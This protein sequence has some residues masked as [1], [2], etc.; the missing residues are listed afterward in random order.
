MLSQ[1]YALVHQRLLRHEI[2]RTHHKLYKTGRSQTEASTQQYTLTPIESL[3]G[4]QN[5]DH[6]PVLV[7][8]ILIQVE[9]GQYYLEDPTGLVLVSFANAVAVDDFFVT[10]HS[11]LLVE[12][13][14]QDEILYVNRIGPPFLEQR[15]K[16]LQL[17]QQQVRHP[18]FLP[19]RLEVHKSKS[20][21]VL[22]NV[23]LDQPR[24]LKLLKDLL[25]S[26]SSC[27]RASD[28]PVFCFMG[29]F[30]SKPVH[31]LTSRQQNASQEGWEDFASLIRHFEFLAN[32]AQF[33]F[34]PGPNDTR[35]QILP[36]PPLVQEIVGLRRIMQSKK[37]GHVHWGSNPCR[38]R[39]CGKEMVFFRQ[40]ILQCIMQNNIR[41]PCA[42]DS[43]SR[44]P[45]SRMAKTILDQG[46][47]LP[48][49]R[50]P[51]YWNYDHAL[52]LYPLPD[53]MVLGS[54]SVVQD[55]EIYENCD[56]IHPGSFSHN[57]SY[58]LYSM[59]DED[60]LMNDG[61]D[62]EGDNS[63]SHLEFCQVKEAQT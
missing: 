7:L 25:Q 45:H 28:L 9:E 56:S 37:V 47:L 40:D 60:D 27:T 16:T 17:L 12:A 32:N 62:D 43:E 46:H 4:R 53:T 2:F 61:D 14:F 29:N 8:G 15:K 63:A 35:S 5:S 42:S 55:F 30:S 41:L 54:S 50:V 24:V 11:I 33:V 39:H 44:P 21:V 18:H 26:Y 51:I 34:I 31:A 10:E 57:G 36:Q 38:I 13:T 22:S 59:Q 48:I 52:R 19:S 6:E 20:F 1:R 23:H 3:L 49:A 58:V